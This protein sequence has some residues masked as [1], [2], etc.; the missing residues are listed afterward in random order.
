[1]NLFL[2]VILILVVHYVADFICQ[3]DEIA[4]KK[5]DDIKALMTHIFIYT[6]VFF[7][8]FCLY[9]VVLNAFAIL[10][11]PLKV[12]I[13]IG[14]GV[15]IVNAILHYIVDYF[16]SK[17]CKYFWQ[18]E[19]RRNFFLVIGFDQLLHT[20]LLIYCYAE[21]LNNFGYI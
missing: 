13:Q 2:G 10:A 7:I 16:T 17:I 19:Q 14:L 15:S 11:I 12:W 20:S 6:I 4:T 21:M 1:M 9:G 3:P 5:S 8:L 18:K